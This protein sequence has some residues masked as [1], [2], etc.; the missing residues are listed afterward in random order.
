[1]SRATAQSRRIAVIAAAGVAGIGIFAA[2]AL[3]G[4]RADLSVTTQEAFVSATSGSPQ[5]A[6]LYCGSG[7]RVMDSSYN[8]QSVDNG[9]SFRDVDVTITRQGDHN[10]KFTVAVQSLVSTDNGETADDNDPV[11]DGQPVNVTRRAAVKVFATCLGEKTSEGDNVDF[12]HRLFSPLNL[13]T[14]A[15]KGTKHR[16]L[17]YNN[18][19]PS[20]SNPDPI[21][22]PSGTI[23]AGQSK[24]ILLSCPKNQFGNFALVGDT[25]ASPS[26]PDYLIGDEPRNDGWLFRIYNADPTGVRPISDWGLKL[27]CVQKQTAKQRSNS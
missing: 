9:G 7:A 24:D 20:Q 8:V 2:P 6:T 15:T 5:Q 1:M 22:G 11:A 14:W 17:V 25:T 26:F 16:R 3:A 21:V 12:V 23:A 27:Y 19:K 4:T 13:P 10:V 18:D